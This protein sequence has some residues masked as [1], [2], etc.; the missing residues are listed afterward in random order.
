M[1]ACRER[2][3]NPNESTIY[4]SDFTAPP[5]LPTVRYRRFPFLTD[6]SKTSDPRRTFHLEE[7]HVP[8]GPHRWNSSTDVSPA[9]GIGTL[10]SFKTIQW[11]EGKPIVRAPWPRD[12]V[13]LESAAVK[14]SRKSTTPAGSVTVEDIVGEC[15]YQTTSRKAGKEYA[16]PVPQPPV[17]KSAMEET[18]DPVSLRLQ[19]YRT[20]PERWQNFSFEWDK[21][22]LRDSTRTAAEKITL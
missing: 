13:P 2:T 8:H 3:D 12:F 6:S 5:A 11:S 1:P 22:Q 14:D 9:L 15:A 19:R 17:P 20:H 7:Q 21:S 10:R 16:L 4:S 18:T